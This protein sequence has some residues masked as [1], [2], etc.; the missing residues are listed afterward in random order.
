MD[1]YMRVVAALGFAF[2]PSICPESAKSFLTSD[3][4]MV[5]VI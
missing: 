5:R 2:A 3:Y 4:Y 1:L